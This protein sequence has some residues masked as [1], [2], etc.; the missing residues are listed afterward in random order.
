MEIS[1]KHQAFVIQQALKNK[2]LYVP[3]SN[4]T[5]ILMKKSIRF[6]CKQ[7]TDYKPR[8]VRGFFLP[9]CEKV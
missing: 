1:V 2:L 7:Y 3:E 4:Y 6:A 8:I 9:K 5:P